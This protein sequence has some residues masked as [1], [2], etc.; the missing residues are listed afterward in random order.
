MSV[1]NFFNVANP[2][3]DEEL[4]ESLLQGRNIRVERI[5]SCGQ[6]TPPNQ[7]YDAQQDE[8]VMVL[9]GTARLTLLDT[10]ITTIEMEAGS[11]LLIPAHQKHR[12]E[13]TS[14]DPPCIWLAIHGQLT[15]QFPRGTN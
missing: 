7:W 13:F 3:N 2:D 9:Q 15:T 11:Y 1:S 5:V 4:F 14:Q 10:E 6:V 12:V 8:W